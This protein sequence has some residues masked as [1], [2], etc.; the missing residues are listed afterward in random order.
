MYDLCQENHFALPCFGMYGFCYFV[1][2][3]LLKGDISHLNSISL[4]EKKNLFLE[5]TFK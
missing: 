1:S 3:Q 4:S 2:P 5:T